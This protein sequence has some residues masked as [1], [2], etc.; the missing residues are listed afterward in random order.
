[1]LNSS[2]VPLIVAFCSALAAAGAF[3]IQR[4]RLGLE[5]AELVVTTA[6][7][8]SDGQTLTV[9]LMNVGGRPA[10]DVEV[11][12][13]AVD[14]DY[15]IEG[16][17]VAGKRA[18]TMTLPSRTALLRVAYSDRQSGR[19]SDDRQVMVVDDHLTIGRRKGGARLNAADSHVLPRMLADDHDHTM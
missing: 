7:L 6:D 13:G 11:S 15:F 9:T 2:D 16:I 10:Y 1:M 19:I 8:S 4:R 5:S 18:A 12:C 3:A 17:E 14:I